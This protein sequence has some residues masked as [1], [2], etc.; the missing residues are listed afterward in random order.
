[1]E[2]TGKELSIVFLIDAVDYD[3][4]DQQLKAMLRNVCDDVIIFWAE[5]FNGESLKNYD[6]ILEKLEKHQ[7]GRFGRG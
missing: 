1:M 3:R 4:I 2:C 5:D 6:C 7:R